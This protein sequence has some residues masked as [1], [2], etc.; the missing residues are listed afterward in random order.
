MR[1]LDVRDLPPAQRHD[2]PHDAFAALGPG[3][4]LVVGNDHAPSPLS[5]AFETGADAFDTDGHR[6]REEAEDRCV[7]RSPKR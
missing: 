1:R 5:D 7:A 2:H 3:E 6:V 4:T